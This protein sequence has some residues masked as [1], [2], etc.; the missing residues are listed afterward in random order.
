MERAL[1]KFVEKLWKLAITKALKAEQNL[2]SASTCRLPWIL[3]ASSPPWF[4]MLLDAAAPSI[5]QA[6]SPS[7]RGTRV[8]P[9]FSAPHSPWAALE[10]HHGLSGLC[11]SDGWRNHLTN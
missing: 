1:S 11:Q 3:Q 9:P 2:P 4:E 8:R 6:G 7:A 10:A 5:L